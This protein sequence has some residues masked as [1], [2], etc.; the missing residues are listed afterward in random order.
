MKIDEGK[1]TSSIEDSEESD[2]E[3]E[4]VSEKKEMKKIK[5]EE[6]L[7]EEQLT[8]DEEHNHPTVEEE[9]QKDQHIPKN[10]CQK[11]HPLDQIIGDKDVRI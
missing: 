10:R 5:M 8:G 11:N 4:E 7:D 2:Y 9:A 6:Q 3:E 1:L